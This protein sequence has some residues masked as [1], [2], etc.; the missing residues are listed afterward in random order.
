[1]KV[2]GGLFVIAATIMGQ[3][4]GYNMLQSLLPQ[5]LPMYVVC[6]VFTWIGI[7]ANAISE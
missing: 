1:M 7:L 5:Y 2:I 6:I 4:I 3:I